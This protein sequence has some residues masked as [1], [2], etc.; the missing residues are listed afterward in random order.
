[1]KRWGLFLLGAGVGMIAGGQ[2]GRPALPPA[3]VAVGVG[4]L[5]LAVR[6]RSGTPDLVGDATAGRIAAAT[7]DKAPDN[8]P[9]FANLGPRVEHILQLAEA[10]AADQIAEA[11]ATAAQ[12][13]AQARA[14][15]ART[16]PD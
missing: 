14:E 9:T 7:D 4:L 3:L 15:A 13:V 10:Q 16:N 2:L 8:R 5:L 1:M 6:A 12:I 11:K